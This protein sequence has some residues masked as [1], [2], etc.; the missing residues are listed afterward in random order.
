MN[1]HAP[2]GRPQ[3][4]LIAWSDG[5]LQLS[6][7]GYRPGRCHLA[8]CTAAFRIII[9]AM[10]FAAAHAHQG[11]R[12]TPRGQLTSTFTNNLSLA[13]YISLGLVCRQGRL[14]RSTGRQTRRWVVSLTVIAQRLATLVPRHGYEG[15]CCTM[16]N[17]SRSANH[18][19]C[20]ITWLPGVKSI[21]P[22]D[23]GKQMCSSLY[24]V[25]QYGHQ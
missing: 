16:D 7:G 12:T 3:Q 9:V 24:L 13:Q 22:V 5:A 10:R 4:A 25:A 18:R 14:G 23:P 11:T 21:Q 2:L 15:S 17:N 20:I 19:N 1:P 6:V 8:T